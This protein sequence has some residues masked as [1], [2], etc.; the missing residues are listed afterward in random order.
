[1][2]ASRDTPYLPLQPPLIRKA[3]ALN[4]RKHY[5]LLPSKVMAYFPLQDSKSFGIRQIQVQSSSW[6]VVSSATLDKLLSSSERLHKREEAAETV[7]VSYDGWGGKEQRTVKRNDAPVN[8]KLDT[9]W[10]HFKET[11][12]AKEPILSRWKPQR[13][14]IQGV[15]CFLTVVSLPT[16]PHTDVSLSRVIHTHRLPTAVPTTWKPHALPSDLL[17]QGSHSSNAEGSAPDT[18]KG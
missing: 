6:P 1:M 11:S 13:D 8:I 14:F 10:S 15:N 16:P 17:V 18:M 5:I 4:L 2:S 12:K 3:I 7:P 9:K